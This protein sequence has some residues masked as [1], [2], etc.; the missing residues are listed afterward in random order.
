[1]AERRSA[2]PQASISRTDCARSC[3]STAACNAARRI[4][5]PSGT[6]KRT[7]CP[8][9]LNDPANGLPPSC[10]IPLTGRPL[11]LLTFPRWRDAQ[12]MTDA[13]APSPELDAPIRVLLADNQPIL[14]SGLRRCSAPSRTWKWSARRA[15]GRRRSRRPVAARRGGHGHRHARH[16]GLEATRR[17]AS[18]ARRPRPDPDRPRRGA[19]P[20]ARRPGRWLGLRAQEPGRHRLLDAI[21]AVPAARSSSTRRPRRCCWRIISSRVGPARKWTATRP[22]PSASRGAGADRRGVYRAGDRRAPGP[23]PEDGRDLPERAM[24]KLGLPTGPIWSS[25]RSAKGCSSPARATLSRRGQTRQW[26]VKAAPPD[27]W[28]PSRR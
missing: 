5:P 19:V 17:V 6:V 18:G 23:Q 28:P 1:M 11:F 16:D 15:T 10:R 25:T 21:R 27:A 14:R 12:L 4:G 26:G 22:S 24:D 20:V 7:A 2:R 9:S 13:L 8:S 3:S